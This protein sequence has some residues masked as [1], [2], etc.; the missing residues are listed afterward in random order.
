MSIGIA[1]QLPVAALW[2][3]VPIFV[4]A[5]GRIFWSTDIVD[6]IPQAGFDVLKIGRENIV[7][8]TPF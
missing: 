6:V 1:S 4:E 2:N 5:V 7:V 8:P 3:G